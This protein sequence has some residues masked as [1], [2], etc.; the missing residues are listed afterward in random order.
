MPAEINPFKVCSIAP[1]LLFH[2][3]GAEAPPPLGFKNLKT[4]CYRRV[5]RMDFIEPSLK[6]ASG[7]N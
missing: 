3:G 5:N 4:A 7:A 6:N 2:E 1:V